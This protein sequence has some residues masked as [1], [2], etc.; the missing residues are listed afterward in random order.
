[1]KLIISLNTNS[2]INLDIF[3]GDCYQ[4]LIIG[5]VNII[6]SNKC[7]S[8]IEY[9]ETF[10]DAVSNTEQ[11]EAL[12]YFGLINFTENENNESY[13]LNNYV[14]FARTS[15]NNTSC[16]SDGTVNDLFYFKNIKQ[17]TNNFKDYSNQNKFSAKITSIVKL[18]HPAVLCLHWGWSDLVT[19]NSIVNYYSKLFSELSIIAF[20]PQK[21]FL[22]KLYPNT[23]FYF[24]DHLEPPW[25][26]RPKDGQE[27]IQKLFVNNH[28][29]II[30]GHQSSQ[31]LPINMTYLELEPKTNIQALNIEL[32]KSSA[33]NKNQ[34][35]NFSRNSTFIDKI[36]HLDATD[37]VFDERLYFYNSGMFDKDFIF[38]YFLINRC[39]NEENIQFN[40]LAG[41]QY[42]PCGT[43][44]DYVVV[45][46]CSTMDLSKI[47]SNF[48]K[49]FIN[50]QS[51]NILDMLKIIECAK[52]IHVYDSLYC[53]IIY[54]LFFSSSFCHNSLIYYHKYARKRIHKMLDQ[55]L[56]KKSNNWI[57][58]E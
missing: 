20:I 10:E 37:D 58:L 44:S 25:L 12:V 47:N 5:K 43:V 8:S 31:N 54:L 36:K 41:T 14:W 19:C 27:L 51:K 16:I 28:I 2:T 38:K 42:D 34:Y 52:E 49:I 53:V 4:F 50:D 24:I 22:L 57:I 11:S 40:K 17:A 9:Y 39:Y 56:I 23:Q 30:D 33:Y 18:K 21:E 35:P 32:L 13:F 26:F 15:E 48:R 29:F 55:E 46:S 3:K 1:M 6:K 45:H 7:V